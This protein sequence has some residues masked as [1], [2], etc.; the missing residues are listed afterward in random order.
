MPRIIPVLDVLRG[1][2][3]RAVAGRRED[4]RPLRSGLRR[5]SDPLDVAGAVREAFGPIELYLAD[6]DAIAGAAP[7]VDLY[8]AVAGLGLAAWIDAGLVD[9]RGVGLVLGAGAARVVIGLETSAGRGAVRR[10]VEVAGP[11]RTAFSLDL[12]EGRPIVGPEAR[13]GSDDPREIVDGVIE[14]GITTVL[15]LD[16]ARVGTGRGVGTVAL[17]R[18]LKTRH[19]GVEWVVGGGVAGA[20]DVEGLGRV[21]ASAVLVGSAIHDGRIT[22]ADAA[23]LA[24][25]ATARG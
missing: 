1:Q 20:S 4:Y 5:G 11:D 24:R 19:P 21:G 16:L 3:V 10:I 25:R 2:A 22:P 23:R 9:T 15:L 12:R 6:L 13:W 8:R 7:D 18:E 14:E 17:L